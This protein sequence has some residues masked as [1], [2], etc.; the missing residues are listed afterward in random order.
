[1]SGSGL[2]MTD[3]FLQPMQT[4]G[5]IAPR[6]FVARTIL[7]MD[8]RVIYAG[9]SERHFNGQCVHSVGVRRQLDAARDPSRQIVH[10][11]QRVLAGPVAHSVGDQELGV[12]AD[13]CEG[14]R[15]AASLVLL[16]LRYVLFLA[17]DERPNLIGLD[18]IGLY[19]PYQ[20]IVRI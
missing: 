10:E 17:S 13:R 3:F 9:P 4:G 14:P 8:L 15:V 19:V 20:L 6:C 5:L 7:F 12:P 1:M 18:L 16:L 2:P 11:R